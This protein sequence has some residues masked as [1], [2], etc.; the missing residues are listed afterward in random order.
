[1]ILQ[2]IWPTPKLD[3]TNKNCTRLYYYK[4]TDKYVWKKK[5]SRRRKYLLTHTKS[6]STLTHFSLNFTYACLK[7]HLSGRAARA[8]A[9]HWFTLHRE[10]KS[11]FGKYKITCR[12]VMLDHY[13]DSYLRWMTRVLGNGIVLTLG[14]QCRDTMCGIQRKAKKI[15]KHIRRKSFSWFTKNQT[16]NQRQNRQLILNKFVFNYFGGNVNIYQ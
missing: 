10:S 3:I 7:F 9:S 16:P 14:S 6:L 2:Y 1:M 12:I 11:G 8:P 15:K 4:I 5:L 13:I